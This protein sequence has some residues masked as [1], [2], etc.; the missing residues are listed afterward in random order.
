[1]LNERIIDLIQADVDGELAAHDRAELSRELLQSQEARKFRDDMVRIN[2]L[3]AS[4]PSL[5]PPAGLQNKIANAIKLPK[6]A[7]LPARS[8]R[9]FQPAGYGLSLA[10]GLLM[11]VGIAQFSTKDTQ[12]LSAVVG[13]MMSHTE[14]QQGSAGE[15]LA[16][17]LDY[18]QGNIKRSYLDQ[19]LALEFDLKSVEPVEIT[20]DLSSTGLR[21]GGFADQERAAAVE[22]FEV[23]NGKVHLVSS[24]NQQYVLF[25]RNEPEG[26]TGLQ[27]IGIS[28]AQ[29]GTDIFQGE[30]DSGQ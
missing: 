22:K 25:L 7:Q 29:H 26:A 4:I 5:D 8:S 12:D 16:V 1:M 2:E 19:A 15:S 3:M 17:S 11:G 27:D 6:R 20:I 10:A 28:L 23:S 24:G 13:T 21:F 18:V 30:L 9:W 14:V